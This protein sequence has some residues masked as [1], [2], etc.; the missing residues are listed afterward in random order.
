MTGWPE[1]F[2]V[3]D[4]TA[5]TVANLLMEEIFPRHGSMLCL[6]TDNGSENVNRVMK[7][8]LEK[9]YVSHVLTSVSH[10]QSNSKVERFLIEHYMTY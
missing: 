5:Q 2:A 1:A 6:V 4:K 7:E 3:P 10:P 9:L 8:T